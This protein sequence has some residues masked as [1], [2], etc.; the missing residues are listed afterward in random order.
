MR[1][2]KGFTFIEIIIS[3]AILS[4]V[5]IFFFASI[6]SHFNILNRTKDITE[7]IFLKQRE[8]E[9]EIDLVKQEIQDLNSGVPVSDP[10]TVKQKTI[11][12]SDLG[13][14]EV[15]YY[16]IEKSLNNKKY[17]TLISDVKPEP[18]ERIELDSIDAKLKHNSLDVAY[19]YA[20]SDFSIVGEFS[21]KETYK[22]DH[23][24]N[25]VEWYAADVKYN[26]PMPKDDNFDMND[27]LEYNSYYF[28][29]FPRDYVLVANETV[30]KFGH[31]VSVFNKLTQYKGR[32]IIYTVTP[33][34][35]SGKLGVRMESDPI[36]ISGLSTMTDLI[37][38]FDASYIDVTMSDEVQELN[39]NWLLNKWFD[40]S[41]IVG[42]TRPNEFA[43]PININQKPTVKR[44]QQDTG[45]TYQYV[46][47]GDNQKLEI[48]KNTHDTLTV[49]SV[50]R[51][52]TEE[53]EA[54]YFK[55][56]N[57]LL[58][59]GANE[60]GDSW[61]VELDV[62]LSENDKFEIG[63]NNMDI[64]ELIVYQGLLNQNTIDEVGQY[65]FNKYKDVIITGNIIE[66]QDMA[67]EI[68]KGNIFEMPYMVPA[69]LNTGIFKD[70]CVSWSG[71]PNINVAG[72]YKIIG[73]AL[74]DPN[75]KME[76]TIT[77]VD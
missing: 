11:F 46:S 29:L 65:L 22:Y 69:Q 70:V 32:H 37:M 5:S 43:L 67:I 31:S 23:L 51:N 13:G 4:I 36:F 24:L 74:A 35:K 63:G 28:P 39:G 54:E 1:G 59:L 57:I 20:S 56:K 6:V 15:S 18:L 27:N 33:A 12:A 60:S 21:N 50:V 17:F 49:L 72:T 34:A 16:E 55:N 77:V 48:T 25:Q 47:F 26:M 66:L 45:F 71:Y 30:H 38:H 10:R 14:I 76:Y 9:E 58:K 44:T 8:I 62:I 64:A 53:E 75:K 52:R 68:E 2:N 42:R 19:G 7:E 3:I 40:V 61:R 41:S 73:T